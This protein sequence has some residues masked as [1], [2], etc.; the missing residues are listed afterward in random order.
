MFFVCAYF[1]YVVPINTCLTCSWC[2]AYA[3]ACCMRAASLRALGA[4]F[5]EWGNS[6][7]YYYYFIKTEKSAMEEKHLR[8]NNVLRYVL[9]LRMLCM[10][11][12][13]CEGT[14][15]MLLD[16]DGSRESLWAASSQF[17]HNRPKWCWS[18]FVTVI[19]WINCNQPSYIRF[20]RCRCEFQFCF[21]PLKCL[22]LHSRNGQSSSLILLLS[23]W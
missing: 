14:S 18:S 21:L 11:V 13:V 12:W 1:R 10:A 9:V 2:D 16:F 23:N 15:Y 4:H 20:S 6:D 17:I 5:G 8:R 22:R 19:T 7:Y 3:N